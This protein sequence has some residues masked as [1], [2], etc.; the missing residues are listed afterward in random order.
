MAAGARV[1]RY[2]DRDD[3]GSKLAA[4]LFGLRS[5]RP[6][7]LGLPR[8]G[9]VV[10]AAV[11]AGLGARL[12]VLVVRKLGVPTQPELAM[13]AVGE[14]GVVVYDEDV[15]SRFEVSRFARRRVEARERSELRRRLRAYRGDRP[16]PE[17]RGRTVV[18][19]DDGI[20]T[21][22]TARAAV[23]VLRRRGAGRIVVAAP[24]ASP[25]AVAKLT[26]TADAVICPLVPPR[27]GSI[28]DWYADFAPTD[29]ARV[30]ELLRTRAGPH[31]PADTGGV[32]VAT[33]FD[34]EIPVGGF[35]TSGRL[36]VVPGSTATVVFAHGS[37]SGRDSPRNVK[38]ARLLQAAGC[39]TL[40]V[41]LLDPAERARREPVFD[42]EILGRRL[43][44]ATAWLRGRAGLADQAVGYFGASTGAAAALW[45]A[46]TPGT[47]IGAVVS[48]GG[49]P[50]L[51]GDRLADVRVPTLLIVGG[52]DRAVLELNRRARRRLACPSRLEVV[53]GAG[54]LFDRPGEMEAV[55]GLARRWFEQHLR[56]PVPQPD[57]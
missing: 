6:L 5:E 55:A 41:D 35:V 20:A 33:R 39:S 9:V 17:V 40:L 30:V 4:H 56:A 34:V 52:E 32:P 53:P 51:L 16:G 7:V 28:G 49:R 11:A 8:G 45:A 26:G 15:L 14:S 31:G 38:V 37:G 21:G 54:H 36:T 12:D 47:G 18:V 3:A 27:L 29:D 50:D 25:D 44:D 1:S 46:T 22:S 23:A 48:R 57:A 43:L 24:V 42:T 2:R 19:V 13:G 10:A